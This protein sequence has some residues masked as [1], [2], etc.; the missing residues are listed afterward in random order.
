LG[1]GLT[2]EPL[3]GF[4]AGLAFGLAGGPIIGLIAGLTAR[5]AYVNLRLR[6]RGR[7]LGRK[8]IDKLSMAAVIGLVSVIM[9]RL[10]F[11]TFASMVGLGLAFGLTVAVL[12]GFLEWVATPLSDDLAQTPVGTLRRD[13]QLMVARTISVVFVGGFLIG[14]AN[15]LTDGSAIMLALGVEGTLAVVAVL[16]VFAPIRRLTMTATASSVYLCAVTLLCIHRRAPRKMMRFLDDAHR[17]GLLRQVG[18][19]YQFRHAKLQDRLA[20]TYRQDSA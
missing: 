6:G 17:V 7:V 2:G 4:V 20:R 14:L 9:D 5:P 8:I 10:G 1:G 19:I 13:L 11:A 16:L 3:A 18:P 12:A 15:G